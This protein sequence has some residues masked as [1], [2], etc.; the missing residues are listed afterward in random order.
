MVC[1]VENDYEHFECYCYED[2]EI[3]FF[4]RDTRIKRVFQ[5]GVRG[6]DLARGFGACGIY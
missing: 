2:A 1:S 4:Y 3:L 6:K 5:D